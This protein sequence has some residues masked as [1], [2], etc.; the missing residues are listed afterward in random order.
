MTTMGFGP[1]Y[2]SFFLMISIFA[3]YGTYF[4]WISNA[5]PRPPAKRAAVYAFANSFGNSASIW[6]P[7][8]Y[9][10]VGRPFYRPAM[11]VNIALQCLGLSC[12]IFMNYHLRQL[13]KRRARLE[14]EDVPLTEKEM[15]SLRKTAEVEG[16]DIA[17]ARQLQKGF[18]Y[19]I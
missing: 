14:D 19:T 18:R 11:G 7:Y 10:E 3:Q 12:A 9:R 2:L 8:T 5:V 1:R 16:I 17:A 6:T 4:G 13:N 15:E